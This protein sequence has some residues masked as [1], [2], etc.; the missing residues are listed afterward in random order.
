MKKVFLFLTMLLF[1]F[2]GT[3]RAQSLTVHDGTAISGNVPVYGFYADAYNK[4]EMVYP[5]TELGEMAGGMINSMTFY[6]SESSVSWGANF[7][8]FLAEVEDAT[9]SAF[10]GPGTV[11]YEGSLDISDGEMVVTFDTPYAYAGGNLLVGVYQTSTGSY[12]TSTWYGESVTGASGSGYNYGSLASCSFGQKNFLPKTT[13][14]YTPAGGG[15]GGELVEVTIGDPTATTTNSYIPTYSLYEKS[16]TQQIYTA[17]EI[18]VGGTINS[19][20]MW[21]K[22]SSSYARNINIYMTESDKAEYT[23]GNEWVPMTDANLVA[24]VVLENGITD[25]VEMTFNLST[26]FAYSGNENLVI[27][28]QDVTGSWSGGA[29]GVVMTTETKQAVYAYRDGTTYDPADPGVTGTTITSKNVIRLAIMTGGGEPTAFST[30]PDVLDLGYRP[31]GAWMAPYTFAINS[32]IGATTVTMLDFSGSYF[33]FNAE[34][35]ATV[36]P[37]NPL[38]VELSTSTATEGLVESTMTIVYS[39][40]RDIEQHDVTAYAY[41]PVEGDVW[42]TAEE[43]SSFPYAGNA[44]AGIYKNYELPTATEGADAMYKVTFDNDV[45][46]SAGTAGENAVTAIYPEGFNGEGGPMADNNY[47]YNGPTVNPG[48]ISMWF[49]YDYTG[50]N[51]WYG[52]SAGGGM[53]WGYKITPAML[54]ELGLGNC[55]IT[56]VETAA[57]NATTYEFYDLMLL[58]GGDTPDLNNIVYYQEFSDFTPGYYFD[59]NLDEPQFLGDDENIWVMF[60]SDAPYA[61]YCG[62]YPVDTNNGKIWYTLDYST[63]YSTTTY[64][65]EMYTRFLELPTGREVTVNLADMKIRESKPAEG[66]MAE[67]NGDVNGVAKAQIAQNNRGNRDQQTLIEQGFEDGMGDWTMYNCSSY[68]GITTSNTNTGGYCFD[69]YYTADYPQYLISPELVDNNGGTMTFYARQYSNGYPESYKLGY[70]TTT[71][72]VSAFT[73]GAEVTDLTLLYAE[74]TFDFPAGTKYVCIACTSNDMFHMYVDDITITADITTGG[75]TPEPPTATYQIEDMYVPA[76]TYYV[77]VASTT[78]E[79]NVDMAVAEVPAPEQAIVISPYDGET[80][81]ESGSI[82]EWIIGDYTTEMQVLLGTQYPPQ[83]ILIDWTTN[84]VAGAFLPELQPNQSYFMQVNERNASYTTYGEIIAFTT[85][86]DPVEGLAVENEELYPGD[87][88]ALTWTANARTLK[89]YNVYVDGVKWNES[90]INT[91]AYDVEG[92]EYNMAGYNITVTSVYDAGESEPSEAVTVFMTGNGS[93]SGHAYDKPDEDT[94]AMPIAFATVMFVGSDEYGVEQTFV[95]EADAEGAFTGEILAGAY[96]AF[97]ITEGYDSNITVNATVNYNELTDEIDI[98]THEFYYPVG[99]VTATDEGN[100][101]LVE[102][103]WNPAELIIDFETGDFSQAEFTLPAQ[104]PWTVT[105]TNPYEGTYCMKSTCEGQASA[106]S[107]I[108]VTAEVPYDGLMGFWVR[109]STEQ[110]YD[111]FH[112]YIDGVEMGAALSGEASYSYKEYA[113]TEGTHVYKFEYTKDSSVNSNDDCVYVDNITMYKQA[114]PAPSS[115]TYTF[116]DSSMMGWTSIDADGDGYGWGVG[117]TSFSSTGLGHDG[118]TDMVVSASYVNYVGALN[119]DN[120]LV[121]PFKMAAQNGAAISFWACGQ[122][123]SYVAE[124][125]GVAVSTGSNTNANDFTTIQEWT[126]TAKKGAVVADEYREV[127]GDR[128]QGSYYEYTVD[129]SAYAGQEIWVAIRHFNCTDMFYLD[130]DDITL[131]DG[132]E[133][134][135]TRGNREF[136]SFNVYRRNN[137]DPES[138]A[139]PELIVEGTTEFEYTD[140]AWETL[141]FGEWQW[142]VAAT[143]AGY[144]PVPERSRETATYGFEDGANLDGWTGIIVNTDGGE[145]LHS[146]ENLGGYDYT[147][148]A[149]T[150][151][152]FAMCYSYVDYDGAYNTNAYL[153]SPQK[154]SVDASSTISF[155]ADNANDSY[156]ENFSVC[157]STAANPTAADFTEI[158]S[159]GAKGTGNGGAA[160]RHQNNRYQNWRSHEI[161]LAAYAGQEIWIAFHDVNYDQYEIW[162]DDV[163]ITYAGGAPVPPTPGPTGSGISEIIWSN[164]IEKDMEATLTFNV[165]L[166]NGQSPEGA[167]IAVVGEHNTYNETVGETGAVAMVVRKGD[168][169]D[170]TVSMD[171]YASW[172]PSGNPIF[173]GADATYTVVLNEVVGPVDGLYV[174]PTGWAMWEGTTAGGVTP[175]TPPTPGE[176][177]EFTE[178]FEGGMPEGWTIVD[179]NNDGWTWCMTSNIPSTWTYYASVSLDWYRTGTN[180]ICSGSYI[181]GAGALNPDEYLIMGQ[182]KIANGSTL[183]FWAAATDA[184]YPADHFG[185]FVSDDGNSWTSV[186]EWTLTGKGGANGGRESRNGN[187][188]KLGTWYNYTADLS[189]YAGQKYIAIRHF[190]CYDQYIMCVDDIELTNGSKGNRAPISYKVMLDGTY[191][192]ESYYPFYQHD[193]DG[194]EEGEVHVTSVAPLYASGMGDWETYTW[195]Y[196]SCSNFAGV[197]DFTSSVVDRTVTLNWTLPGGGSGGSASTFTEGFEGGMPEGWTVVDANNDGYTWCMTSNIPST[198]TYYASVSLDWYRTG[199]NAICSGSYINGAGALNPDEYLIM[200][201]QKIANGSTLSFWAA[202]TDASYPADHFGV[203]VSDDGNSWTSVQ[204]WTLTGK[205][206]ANGGRESRN[207]NGAK[208]GT[209]YNYTADLSAYAGQKYIAIRHFNCYDQYIMCVDDIELSAGKGV[210]VVSNR[211]MWDLLGTFEAPEGGHYG[212]VTDGEYIYTSNWGYSGAANN[213]YKYD[214]DGNMIEGF[215]ISGCGTLRG[216]TFDGQYVYGVANSSTIYCVDLNNHTLVGTT[217]SAYGAMRGITYDSERDGFW[218]IGNWSGNLTLIDR[219]GAIVQAGPAPTSASDLAYYKDPEGVEH[220]FCFNNGTN[221]VDDYNIATNTITSA[222]FNFNSTPGYAGGSSGGCHVATYAGKT[223]FFGDIQQSPNLIA[224]YELDGE[225]PV[226]PTPVEGILGAILFRD[227]EYVGKFGTNTT[228]YTEELETSGQFTYTIRVIYDGAPD[229]TYYAM[230]CGDD[231]IVTVSYDVPETDDV[232]SSIYPNPTS[233]ELHI[234]ATAMQHVTVF[235]TMGQVVFSSDVNTDSYVLNMG[236][237]EAGVYMVKVDAEQGSSVKRIAVVK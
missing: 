218:V 132:T 185:V 150:G 57:R 38:N 42:E 216:M 201:Q 231:E 156:P 43:V 144:A 102:W 90:L 194:M 82:A 12:I 172:N 158:W 99:Q 117:S 109:V 19:L 114:G 235:N 50:T 164:V 44:P 129:L 174:S 226:P 20:T 113:V 193:V 92:L 124:H 143:Y 67:A 26:P 24:S 178:G 135:A 100:D 119:P 183:S 171:G 103:S 29:A 72:D 49:S 223:A 14:E 4:C 142:G 8:V 60:Y 59:V 133:A 210:G 139:D 1:A 112:F 196:T 228:T 233:G 17:D 34:L 229:E 97:V 167:A 211:D 30:T 165:S 200:G 77:A 58:K 198:W 10:A 78:D 188:A 169:Y 149:H 71:N 184:S 192:G 3:M 170:I 108:E 128:A 80:G 220:V 36:G 159:G 236:Q 148:L 191:V 86:I 55:A 96:S 187:G 11:V 204:E 151:T 197:T 202:A 120:Y 162:I 13:F 106:T 180:A 177:D 127:R 136:Q 9:I 81:V 207:G 154:Y 73:F 208:L 62:R 37:G 15:G 69:F 41:N 175:P 209:W 186:Q 65:P 173:V 221:D 52:T 153:V 155:W 88:A 203:F 64:T 227:G 195:T 166:N 83:T 146:S 105:T 84:L 87:A 31:N 123:A 176:G 213:F 93:V 95:V 152:G 190:N 70:S 160:V 91:N 140:A 54:Q 5:A 234:T 68:S 205:G 63:W 40:N 115:M 217:T 53:M 18:G 212:V 66:Q 163:T 179:A 94:D 27:S 138:V 33:T 35:P 48:P 225:A 79:F 98:Y 161:S 130:V 199:T 85:P 89:G 147:E 219:T 110:N 230:S 104:Y 215:N 224:I 111:K 237:L 131:G 168:T 118:S 75:G 222:V 46:F 25:P 51:T 232:I 76:G 122:D 134:M 116:D 32:K 121:S 141:E 157:V 126:M 7:Q 28:F 181:N 137:I 206:G 101:V 45:L 61:A 74:K 107:S 125:F 214:M 39:G 56:T 23:V 145:W 6:A 16:Y 189:A 21:L 2:T 182:Q 22:N 47:V